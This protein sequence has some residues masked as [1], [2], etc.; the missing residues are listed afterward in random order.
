M[1]RGVVEVELEASHCEVRDVVCAF[2]K[3]YQVR[4]HEVLR[5]VQGHLVGC[6]CPEVLFQLGGVHSVRMLV[7][8]VVESNFLKPLSV[9]VITSVK[10]YGGLFLAC[11]YDGPLLT[12]PIY[13]VLVVSKWSVVL[14]LVVVSLLFIWRRG[15]EPAGDLPKQRMV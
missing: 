7:F 12:V 9:M 11:G 4:S 14:C 13:T 8:C 6:S 10:R 1:L 15:E 3:V 5:V 2:H